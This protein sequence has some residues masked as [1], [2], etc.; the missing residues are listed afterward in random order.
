MLTL[1]CFA[2]IIKKRG[3]HM[4]KKFAVTGFKGFKDRIELDLSKHRNYEFNGFAIM[5]YGKL[6]DG[7]FKSWLCYL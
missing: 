6:S 7:E 1:R 2:L 4:L 3:M 5:L